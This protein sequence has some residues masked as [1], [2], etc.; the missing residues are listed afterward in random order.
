[1]MGLVQ[2]YKKY[3]FYGEVGKE[4]VEKVSWIKD[5]FL[6]IYYQ[7]SIDDKL[8]VE[9][10]FVQYFVF[11]NLE[12]E[13]RMK[14]LYYLYVSLD[15]NVVKVF[16]EMWKCQNMFWSYVCELLDLYKQ[17]ILEVNCFVMFGKLMIIVK[18]LFDFGK[19]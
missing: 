16:N 17:F 8:L 9:K 11:Y 19:V 4:V 2:F 14:C 7:N 18:N 13:E 6:Y 5:K 12:I 1:M 15:L 3:C 10:I